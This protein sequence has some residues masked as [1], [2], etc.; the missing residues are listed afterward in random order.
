MKGMR[1][2][3]LIYLLITF[4]VNIAIFL[5]PLDNNLIFSFSYFMASIYIIFNIG[6]SISKK[7]ALIIY[8]VYIL[9]TI[10]LN[11]FLFTKI[12]LFVSLLMIIFIIWE[13]ARKPKKEKSNEHDIKKQEPE[14]KEITINVEL[15][16]DFDI[17]E[18]ENIAQKL[19]IKMQT[20]FMNLEYDKL[21]HILDKDLYQQFFTQMKVL[22]KN[23][24]CAVRENIEVIDF[25]INDFTKTADNGLIINTSIGVREE[26]YTRPI[27][28]DIKKNNCSYESYYEIIYIKK[29][30]W[31]I[32]GLKLIY[33]HSSHKKS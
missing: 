1:I 8:G 24:K 22:E 14:K 20:Y 17:E 18:F 30:E 4:L 23:N 19:Y 2:K 33:S 27:D 7:N 29:E 9:I 3:L 31:T 10:L 21:E 15:P 26:K 25:K 28:S 5:T 16:L 6:S 13:R 11:I 32:C 12:N